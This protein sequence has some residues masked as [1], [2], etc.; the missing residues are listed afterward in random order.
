M[1]YFILAL[2]CISCSKAV[3]HPVPV[4]LDGNV[5]TSSNLVKNLGNTVLSVTLKPYLH[6]FNY[7]PGLP[8]IPCEIYVEAT[9]NLSNPIQQSV[10]FE[11][12][13]LNPESQ[14]SFVI[15][16]APNTTDAILN[17]PFPLQT[18]SVAPNDIFRID[19]VSIFNFVN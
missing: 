12:V 9:V 10:S 17:T 6:C 13:M 11:L 18:N 3:N 8:P 19:K 4:Q 16:I 7:R 15:V 5:L 14:S 2:L 1:K